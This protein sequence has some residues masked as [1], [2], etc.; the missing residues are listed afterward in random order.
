MEIKKC[1]RQPALTAERNVKFHSNLTAADRC[2]AENATANEDRP[3]D[4]KLT[5]YFLCYQLFLFLTENLE[6]NPLPFRKTN[7]VDALRA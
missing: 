1:T 2:T 6:N 4:I 5:R 3:E 7:L